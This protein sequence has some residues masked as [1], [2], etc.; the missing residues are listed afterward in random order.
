VART[1]L[2]SSAEAGHF[3]TEGEA[4]AHCPAE[5]VV[6]ANLPSKIY[7]FAGYKNYGTTK[8]GTYMCE[9]EATAQGFRAS[10]TETRP[11]V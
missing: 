2:P 8:N 11:G 3:Q 1:A 4:K 5:I 9:R 10:K 7:H 6:W